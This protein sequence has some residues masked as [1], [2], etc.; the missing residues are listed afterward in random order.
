M[1]FCRYNLMLRCWKQESNKRPIFIDISK[2]LEK[3]MVKNRVGSS[4]TTNTLSL[5]KVV[6]TLFTGSYSTYSAHYYKWSKQHKTSLM[7]NN[8]FNQYLVN[9]PKIWPWSTCA[10]VIITID[11]S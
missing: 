7:S 3:M 2:E 1:C 5:S 6:I 4:K 9:T 11:S 8:K 10:K